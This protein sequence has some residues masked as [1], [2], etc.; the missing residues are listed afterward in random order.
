MC[1][2]K[3]NWVD[4]VENILFDKLECYRIVII[5]RCYVVVLGMFFFV[6]YLSFLFVVIVWKLII[7]NIR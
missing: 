5:S 6:N 2:D 4:Y 3:G 1:I 7:L